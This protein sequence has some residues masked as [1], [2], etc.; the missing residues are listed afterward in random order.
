[1][2]YFR[3]QANIDLDAVRYNLLQVRKKIGSSTKLLAVIKADGYGHGAVP[4]AHNILDLAD[5][6]GVATLEEALEL[7]Y[8][9]V[10]TPILILSY[11]SPS[12]FEKLIHYHITPTIYT[13]EAAKALSK[14]AC[15]LGQKV[16]IHLALETG[17]GRIGFWDR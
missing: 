7:R 1:M 12:Q 15:E 3:V 2:E 11:V 13:L 8:S 14:T 9:G 10:Q 16:K 4:L 6:F 5:Y 17:M